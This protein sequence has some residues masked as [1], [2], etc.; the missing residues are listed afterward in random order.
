MAAEQQSFL[1]LAIM[2]GSY[3]PHASAILAPG[4]GFQVPTAQE[5]G[6]AAK[7]V[8]SL[9]R[10]VE[11]KSDSIT[12]R[13]FTATTAVS[14]FVKPSCTRHKG[15]CRK[16]GIAPQIL[17]LGAWYRS[18]VSFTQ[19]PLYPHRWCHRYPRSEGGGWKGKAVPL[20]AQRVPGR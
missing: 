4:K 18:V 19:R 15:I 14:W 17:K 16:G 3:Q 10:K 8:W 1:T 13:L 6:W 20:K 5:A 12:R 9:W 11:S 2:E 7:L